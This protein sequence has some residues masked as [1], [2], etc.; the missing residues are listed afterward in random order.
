ML[1]WSLY[2]IISCGYYRNATQILRR[3]AH[4]EFL[5]IH[6]YQD[7]CEGLKVCGN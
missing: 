4:T 1:N 5:G 7:T 3:V 2:M 6:G